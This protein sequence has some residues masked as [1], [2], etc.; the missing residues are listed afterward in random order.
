MFVLVFGL[1]NLHRPGGT[2]VMFIPKF[3]LERWVR[4]LAVLL[5]ILH[6]SL[7]SF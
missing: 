3:S 6:I 4:M 7:V 5:S 1:G 2:E